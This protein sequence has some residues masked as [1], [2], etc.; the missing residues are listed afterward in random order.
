MALQKNVYT[1]VALGI[2]G[3]KSSVNQSVYTPLN[4]IAAEGGVS[5]GRFAFTGAEE[6]KAYQAG[7]TAAKL[8]GFV[9]RVVACSQYD[10]RTSGSLVFP[11]GAALTIAV[12]GDYV[13]VAPAAVADG[14]AVYADATGAV[15]MQGSEGAFDTG[16]K[17]RVA[18]QSA[19][20]TVVISNW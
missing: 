8:I 3:M 5:A 17:Y 16:W 12:K 1:R 19:G 18:A 11:E 7:G 10:V 15:V 4:F 2:A 14:E 9:E 20:E 6:G 13:A